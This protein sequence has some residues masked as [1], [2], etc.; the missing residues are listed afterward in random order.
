MA[1]A[2]PLRKL[3]VYF[4]NNP[5]TAI[6]FVLADGTHA[7]FDAQSG[8]TLLDVALDN[9]IPGIVGQCGGGCTCCTC[10]VW[11]DSRWKEA[12]PPVHRDEEDMLL[13]AWARDERSRLACQIL[14][15][16]SLAGI[17]VEV[18]EQQS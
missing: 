9:K 13:Y 10:H 2:V 4:V 1:I 8:D 14:L 15:T 18:P 3:P 7:S 11:I 5:M 17:V 6:T 12:L 16:T